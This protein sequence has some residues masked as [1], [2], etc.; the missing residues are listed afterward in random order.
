MEIFAVFQRNAD[1][2]LKCVVTSNGLAML[3]DFLEIFV[4][5]KRFLQK[6]LSIEKFIVETVIETKGKCVERNLISFFVR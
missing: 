1:V 3:L 4:L 6:G 5:P 2:I